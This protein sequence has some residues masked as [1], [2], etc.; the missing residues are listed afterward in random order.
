MLAAVGIY[1]VMTYSVQ[2]RRHEIGIRIALGASPGDVL[3]LLVWRGVSLSAAG[4]AIG[5]LAALVTSGLMRKLLFGV[6][7]RDAPTFVGIAALVAA[8]G[9]LAA[10][11]PGWRATRV[12]PVT[13]LRGE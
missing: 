10:W 11:M 7:P 8:V 4:V 12:D 3:R 13:A 9:V 2:Q 1:G 6:P 5:V